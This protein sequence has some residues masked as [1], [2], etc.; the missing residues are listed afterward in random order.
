VLV[1]VRGPKSSHQRGFPRRVVASLGSCA[2]ESN[3][4]TR[5][6]GLWSGA[7][8]RPRPTLQETVHRLSLQCPSETVGQV[9]VS[10][11]RADVGQ[12]TTSPP[13]AAPVPQGCCHDKR[14]DP[15]QGE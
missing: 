5:L 15:N 1:R 11:G 3:H 13:M 7:S 2:E 8:A 12:T 14:S 10:Q 9:A 6:H 4:N